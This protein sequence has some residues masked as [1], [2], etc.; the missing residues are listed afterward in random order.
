[1]YCSSRFSR[2]LCSLFLG[3]AATLAAQP[4]VTDQPDSTTA[5]YGG[6]AVLSVTAT[7]GTLSYQWYWQ[8]GDN[9][10][11][12]VPGAT[13]PLLV[14]PPL[15][16]D[17]TFWCEVSDD[18]ETVTSD[19]ATVDVSAPVSYTLAGF[20]RN[21]YGELGT[22][23]TGYATQWKRIAGGVIDVEATA[24]ATLLLRDDGTLL[25]MG[26]S[27]LDVLPDGMVENADKADIGQP[28]VLAEHVS[29]M[30]VTQYRSF[31]V[32]EG[33]LW[34]VGVP[35][36]SWGPEGDGPTLMAHGVTR[37]EAAS[38]YVLYLREDGSLGGAGRKPD[39]LGCGFYFGRGRAAGG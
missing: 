18:T 3:L 1:M 22:G 11:A 16:A 32:K 34:T 5:A 6:N 31:Y 2:A 9:P 39:R 13:G 14:S 17:T 23:T 30:A 25:A 8:Q 27:L 15:A 4:V 26:S 35:L 10:S 24:T 37:V 29:D 7:D 19:S 28:I 12:A 33:R 21:E 20:G 36:G 38:D